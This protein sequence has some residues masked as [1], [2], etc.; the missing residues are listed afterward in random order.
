MTLTIDQPRVEGGRFGEKLGAKPEV[1][2]GGR[3]RPPVATDTSDGGYHVSIDFRHEHLADPAYGRVHRDGCRDSEDPV[4]LGPVK[5]Y[6]DIMF[7]LQSIG[8]GWADTV[9][10]AR[11]L[12]DPCVRLPRS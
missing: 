4:S 6:A 5:S 12:C 1:N 8:E 11:A 7:A 9:E 2:L 10:Q 3:D